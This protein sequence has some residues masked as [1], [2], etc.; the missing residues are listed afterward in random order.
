ITVFSELNIKKTPL[1]GVF[2]ILSFMDTVIFKT[3]QASF[4]TNYSALCLHIHSSP[5]D[6]NLPQR[7][8]I[9]AR[10]YLNVAP[11]AANTNTPTKHDD[12]SQ[13]H[14]YVLLRL[15]LYSVI[16]LPQTSPYRN[17]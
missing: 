3:K 9:H 11:A 13:K 1:M 12:W 7:L 16:R 5:P 14:E 8:L 6:S 15:Q 17:F 2:F 10:N 4:L